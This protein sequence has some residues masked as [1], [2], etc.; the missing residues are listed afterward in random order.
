[1]NPNAVNTKNIN[2]PMITPV[3]NPLQR[4]ILAVSQA[5]QK[6]PRVTH[7]NANG[8]IK[9]SLNVLINASINEIIKIDSTQTTAE[10]DIPIKIALHQYLNEK[11]FF[12]LSIIKINPPNLR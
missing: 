8:T 11:F 9:I 10:N 5:P 6:T 7:I 1:M 2:K 3:T 12:D 4:V